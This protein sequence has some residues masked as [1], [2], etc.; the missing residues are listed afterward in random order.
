MTFTASAT[1]SDTPANTVRFSLGAGTRRARQLIQTRVC[2]RGRR[3]RH[4]A[5]ATFT[6]SIVATDGGGLS[7]TTT[8]A[9]TVREVNTAPSI[10]AVPRQTVFQGG[11]L[12][13]NVDAADTDLPANALTFSLTDAPDGATIDPQTGEISWRVPVAH[14]VGVST[15]TVQV[16][17]AA[18][19]TAEMTFEVDVEQ[20]D[21]TQLLGSELDGLVDE[22]QRNIFFEGVGG[23]GTLDLPAVQRGNAL[24][25][26]AHDHEWQS[27]CRIDRSIAS[28][29]RH[30]VGRKRG[31]GERRGWRAARSAAT[32]ER[33]R[34]W[35]TT[36]SRGAPRSGIPEPVREIGHEYSGRR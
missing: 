22:I 26:L 19:A 20:F 24:D 35:V 7:D 25:P 6:I 1:D 32:V 9:V 31:G 36:K 14:S 23:L 15:I 13:V 30:R 21:I 28:V 12:R 16:R 11:T 8:V 17:D 29:E 33:R 2:L 5:L 3:V 10:N 34:G 27:N 18:G 4:K